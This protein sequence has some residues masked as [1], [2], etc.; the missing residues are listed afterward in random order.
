M[1]LSWR[2]VMILLGLLAVVIVVLDGIRRMRRARAEAL[3]LDIS[4]D[5]KFPDKD[6]N[7]ELPSGGFRVKG[8][9]AADATPADV[10]REQAKPTIELPKAATR[11]VSKPAPRPA[12]AVNV[13]TVADSYKVD[14]FEELGEVRVRTGADKSA[15]ASERDVPQDDILEPTWSET[16]DQ[17]L[18]TQPDSSEI[19]DDDPRFQEDIQSWLNT[20]TREIEEELLPLQQT[21][22]IIPR[23][24]P[25]NLDEEVPVLMAVETLGDREVVIEDDQLQQPVAKAIDAAEAMA[26]KTAAE[27]AEVAAQGPHDWVAEEVEQPTHMD[28]EIELQEEQ[29][30]DQGSELIIYAGDDAEQLSSRSQ[31]EVV[32]VIHAVARDENGFPGRSLL[33]LFDGCDLRYGTERIFHRYEEADGKGPIQFSIAQTYEPGVFDPRTMEDEYFAGLTFF[34]SLPGA[35]RPLEAYQ[36]M[37]EM[38]RVL[39]DHLD[40]DLKDGTL[41]TFSKQTTEHDRQQIQEYERRQALLAK[42]QAAGRRR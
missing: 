1:E 34:M 3:K 42:K 33:H 4:K 5:F 13:A 12:A 16:L 26:D 41:S 15:D 10:N 21:A 23:A 11:P 32:L 25:V 7:P 8:G 18:S 9:A 27:D 20:R 28:E 17:P 22:S 35:K 31:A 14:G 38:A 2:T 19:A 29:G 6:S 40:A 39:A 30:E 37:S 24:K 36:A